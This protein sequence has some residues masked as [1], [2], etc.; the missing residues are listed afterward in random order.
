[1]VKMMQVSFPSA[2]SASIGIKTFWMHETR[3]SGLLAGWRVTVN[4]E[5]AFPGTPGASIHA[6]GGTGVSRRP[7]EVVNTELAL[8]YCRG[9]LWWGF[10]CG[11]TANSQRAAP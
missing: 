6:D 7:I 8:V 3:P 1:M 5:R 10:G 11:R 4:P 2:D 9:G